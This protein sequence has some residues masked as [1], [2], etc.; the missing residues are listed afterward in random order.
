MLLKL[1]F[2]Y[3]FIHRPKVGFSLHYE[4]YDI[5]QLKRTAMEWYKKTDYPQLPHG[6]TPRQD[7]YHQMAI[8]GLYIWHKIW[9]P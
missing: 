6:F 4:P 8:I 3:G 5:P 9:K 7:A 2:D 1:G